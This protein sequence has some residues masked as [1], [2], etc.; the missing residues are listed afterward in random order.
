[1][2][3]RLCAWCRQPSADVF[4]PRCWRLKQDADQREGDKLF[5]EFEQALPLLKAGGDP[6]LSKACAEKYADNIRFWREK[7]REGKRR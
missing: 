2:S 5:H 7:A 6:P 3:D 1:V 4:H